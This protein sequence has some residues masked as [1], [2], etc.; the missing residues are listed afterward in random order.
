MVREAT[1]RGRVNGIQSARNV[2]EA[3]HG[4]KESAVKRRRAYASSVGE[5]VR[6]IEK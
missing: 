3:L 4:R 2:T 1:V 6:V 5:S